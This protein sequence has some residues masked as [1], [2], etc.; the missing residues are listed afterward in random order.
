[1]A[2]SLASN[3]SNSV[4][5]LVPTFYGPFYGEMLAGL[6][7]EL[8]AKGKH[9]VITAGHSDAMEEKSGIEFLLSRSC[10]AL[11]IHADEISDYYLIEL[12]K[13][14]VPIILINRL[15]PE[16]ADHC[17]VLN[18]EQGGYLAARAVLDLGH[19]ELAYISGPHWKADANE[20]LAGHKPAL[21]STGW[22]LT[23]G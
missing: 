7:A 2:Q 9:A 23:S 11:I 3:R 15:I 13:G 19:R 6:E 5:V 21:A 1:M 20:R 16:M 10:D 8:R 18:N 22:R 4:G 14:T 12:S 17:I